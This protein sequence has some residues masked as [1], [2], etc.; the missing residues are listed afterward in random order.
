MKTQFRSECPEKRA[1][2]LA[3]A[4]GLFALALDAGVSHFVGRAAAH[5]AQWIPILLGPALGS[6]IV[7]HCRPS[8]PDARFRLALAWAGAVSASVGA[9]GTFFHARSAWMLLDSG[10]GLA[11]LAAAPPLFAPGGFLAVGALLLMLGARRL[12]IRLSPA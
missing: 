6:G 9:L 2:A 11:A 10:G 3:A 5:P 7:L 4:L 8:V 1:T 12:E